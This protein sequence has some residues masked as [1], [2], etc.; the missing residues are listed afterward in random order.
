[1]DRDCFFLDSKGSEEGWVRMCGLVRFAVVT[2]RLQLFGSC[3]PGP[4]PTVL[5]KVLDSPADWHRFWK[6]TE[7][8]SSHSAEPLA[9]RKLCSLHHCF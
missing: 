2:L 7:T 8:C 5:T 9:V 4:A 1:M 6:C 3:Y